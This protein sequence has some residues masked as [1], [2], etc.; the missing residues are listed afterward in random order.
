[1]SAQIVFLALSR[2]FLRRLERRILDPRVKEAEVWET[3]EVVPE[4]SKSH[5][6]AT[7]VRFAHNRSCQYRHDL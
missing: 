4:E 1:M 2:H 3:L 6:I 7:L 5:Q